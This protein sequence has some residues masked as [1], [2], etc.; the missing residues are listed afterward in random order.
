MDSKDPVEVASEHY[1]LLLDGQRARIVEMYLPAGARDNEHSHPNEFVYFLRGSTV[2]IYEPPDEPADVDL[3][4][5]HVME[6][7]PCTH[8]VENIGERD[9]HA[10]IFELKD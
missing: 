4:E 1:K 2:R 10:I 3:P 7:D 8:S 5:G 6:R 9:I